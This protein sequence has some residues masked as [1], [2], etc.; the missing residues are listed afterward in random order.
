MHLSSSR[1]RSHRIGDRQKAEYRRQDNKTG[2][3]WKVFPVG[4]TKVTYRAF[5]ES[6]NISN[7]CSFNIVVIDDTPP[8]FIA[9][10]GITMECGETTAAPWKNLNEFRAA[11]GIATDNCAL[12]ESSF[13]LISEEQDY[14]TCPYT[15]SSAIYHV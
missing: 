8:E 3:A 7:E 13:K 6:G 1:G 2:G 12:D 4:T 14:P 15:H 9:P 5:D 11:G 10:R